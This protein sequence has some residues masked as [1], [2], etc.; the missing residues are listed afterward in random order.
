MIAQLK[1][2]CETSRKLDGIHYAYIT[3]SKLPTEVVKAMRKEGLNITL[4]RRTEICGMYGM[5]TRHKWIYVFSWA[6]DPTL[7]CCI[8]TC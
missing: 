4:A 2:G 1:A 7:D 8:E 6:E 5:D 3:Y